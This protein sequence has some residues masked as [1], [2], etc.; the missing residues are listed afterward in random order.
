[1]PTPVSDTAILTCGPG[2][3]GN[4]MAA[5]V[6]IEFGVVDFDGQTAAVVHGIARVDREV[7][8]HLLQLGGIG[9]DRGRDPA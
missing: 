3:T 1:M 6:R 2:V 5:V 4:V 7:H 8:H 9:A